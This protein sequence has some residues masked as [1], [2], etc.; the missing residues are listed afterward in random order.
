MNMYFSYQS[1]NS[2]IIVLQYDRP[3]SHILIKGLDLPTTNY[4]AATNI[5]RM[6]DFKDLL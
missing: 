4:T 6:P 5:K 1:K 2:I 3:K